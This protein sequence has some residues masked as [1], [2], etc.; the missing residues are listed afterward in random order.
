MG[1]IMILPITLETLKWDVLT[2]AK[3]SKKIKFPSRTQ[4]EQKLS[5]KEK[6]YPKSRLKVVYRI[7]TAFILVV[8]LTVS[9]D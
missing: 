7:R 5:D 3:K 9:N 8:I 6:C 4:T 1:L 2:T